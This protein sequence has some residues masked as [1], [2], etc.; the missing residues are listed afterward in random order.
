MPLAGPGRTHHQ[1]LVGGAALSG[2]LRETDQGKISDRAVPVMATPTL[3]FA[4][5]A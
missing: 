2:A 1:L 5:P 4:A 3:A